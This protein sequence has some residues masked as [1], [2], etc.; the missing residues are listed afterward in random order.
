MDYHDN[1]KTFK[2]L[3]GLEFGL[4][5]KLNQTGFTLGYQYSPKKLTASGADFTNTIQNTFHVL[6][7]ELQQYIDFIVLG[8]SIDHNILSINQSFESPDYG[9]KFTSNAWSSHF[10]AGYHHAGDNHFGWAL[11]PYVKI[12]WTDHDLAALLEGLNV[13]QGPDNTDFMQFGIQIILYN[14]PQDGD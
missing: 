1:F 8:A 6:K 4:R 13:P 5:Y 11:R 3:H 10:S 7:F 2:F 9:D 14:G 12:Y